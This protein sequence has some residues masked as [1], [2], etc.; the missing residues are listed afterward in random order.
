MFLM[1]NVFLVAAI[2]IMTEKLSF[3]YQPLLGRQIPS[4]KHGAY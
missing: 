4:S 2:A 3:P 1:K